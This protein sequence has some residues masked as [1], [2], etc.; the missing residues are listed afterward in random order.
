MEHKELSFQEFE[1]AFKTLKRNKA[2]GY[3]GLGGNI[4]MDVYNSIKVILF[5]KQSFLKNLKSQKLFKF[6]KEVIKKMW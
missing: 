5:K 3:D 6:L 4:I 1:K 2:I